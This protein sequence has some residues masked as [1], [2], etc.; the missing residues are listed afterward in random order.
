M[1]AAAKPKVEVANSS[2]VPEERPAK[3]EGESADAI[4]GSEATAKAE[5]ATDA[6]GAAASIATA[7]TTAT[8]TEQ[9]QEGKA[10]PPVGGDDDDDGGGKAAAKPTGADA[11]G[12]TE[13]AA[14]NNSI[15]PWDT[16]ELVA[17]LSK[18]V[19]GLVEEYANEIAPLLLE[20]GYRNKASL[21]AASRDDLKESGIKPGPRGLIMKWINGKLAFP[22][23]VWDSLVPNMMVK[24][25][26]QELPC[27]DETPEAKGTK[28]NLFELKTT[29][30]EQSGRGKKRRVSKARYMPVTVKPPP[31]KQW[32][33][34][35][36][37]S[38]LFIRQCT[39][40]CFNIMWEAVQKD[41]AQWA[42]EKRIDGRHVVFIITGPP[43]LG[44]SWSSNTIV[45]HLLQKRQN[46]WFHSASGRTLTTF[47]FQEGAPDP[48]ISER[49]EDDVKK[50]K[51]PAGTWFLYDSVG[52][53]KSTDA[54][55]SFQKQP[56]GVFC[57]IFS[58]PKESSYKTGIK[59][60]Q[61]GL[62]W[63]LW[64]PSWEW[65]ELKAVMKSLY[66][67]YGGSKSDHVH[68]DAV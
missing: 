39:I 3:R 31:S 47:E 16:A 30:E 65:P 19:D 41:K 60:M 27:I 53:S 24:N 7:T 23:S 12:D 35:T 66:K 49:P 18:N 26:I 6:A 33:Q 5:K 29:E 32:Y 37:D 45:W 55:L 11:N 44:K 38:E 2:S 8:T 14:A 51:T 17:F 13:P 63:R 1:A 40:D 61:D 57:V 25:S 42:K 68:F 43:G 46:I 22:P 56:P 58:S 48:I 15:A 34:G 52:G 4:V 9:Q 20:N 59:T 36:A 62:I 10:D 54:M 21:L 67:E 28:R 64:T 50:Y